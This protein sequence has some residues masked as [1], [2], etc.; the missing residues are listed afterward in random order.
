M[1]NL[2]ERGRQCENFYNKECEESL[3]ERFGMKVFY[4]KY[5]N[6]YASLCNFC[7]AFI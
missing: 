1:L 2:V 7:F 4:E 6:F 5:K 3:T